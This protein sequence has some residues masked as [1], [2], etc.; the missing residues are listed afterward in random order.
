[1]NARHALQTAVRDVSRSNGRPPEEPSAAEELTGLLALH[2]VGVSVTG[3]T[4]Y[5]RGSSAI[6][7][8]YL[9]DGSKLTLDP[10]GKYGSPAKLTVEL[11]IQVGAQPKLNTRGVVQAMALLHKLA[12][13]HE[14]MNRETIAIDRGTEFLQL[15]AVLS[16]DMANQAERWQAFS[17]LNDSDPAARARELGTSIARQCT[18]NEDREGTRYVRCGWFLSFVRAVAGAY[19]SEELARDMQRV[20]W[21][22]SGKSGRIK[23]C[24][25][26]HSRELG[27]SFYLV[28]AGWET[29]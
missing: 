28:H 18:V 1:V 7:E 24:A 27:W 23:A 4:L 25:P 9:S 2:G 6:A 19:S 22:R 17:S 5:G 21:E 3:A 13:H 16:V 11:A 8:I 20:G 26:G 12:V 10:I 15:A 29:R 14:T